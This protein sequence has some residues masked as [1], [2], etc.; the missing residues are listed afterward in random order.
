V[1]ISQ[2]SEEGI[3]PPPSVSVEEEVLHSLLRTTT[4]DLDLSN[5]GNKGAENGRN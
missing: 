1:V 5:E 2:K 4:E 3:S